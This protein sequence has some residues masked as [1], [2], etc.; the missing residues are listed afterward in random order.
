[1]AVIERWLGYGNPDTSTILFIG[2]EEGGGWD[3]EAIVKK[4]AKWGVSFEEALDRMVGECGRGFT[5]YDKFKDDLD[6]SDGSRHPTE[7]KQ[8]F[9]SLL[10]SEEFEGRNPDKIEWEARNRFEDYYLSDFCREREF[11][12]NLYPMSCKTD[13]AWPEEYA[14]WFGVPAS[15]AEYRQQVLQPR[16]DMLWELIQGHLQRPGG[17]VF[18]M[19]KKTVWNPLREHM[20]KH[21]I[22]VHEDEN[23]KFMRSPDRRI[24]FL[25]HP[26]GW[27]RQGFSYAD[28][29]HVVGQITR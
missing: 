26:C 7:R 24:W 27:G 14:A 28:A 3:G 13:N 6:L 20:A 23:P 9:L 17:M 11:M 5:T 25:P 16:L 10:L 21:G 4:Q 19:G 12:T 2:I 29:Q 1:M 18:V 22:T 15:K 8:V